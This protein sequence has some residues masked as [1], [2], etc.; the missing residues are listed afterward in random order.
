[1]GQL[2][3]D[4]LN[5]SRITRSEMHRKTVDLSA[6]AKKIATELQEAQPERQAEFI[7]AEKLIAYGDPQ[8][9]RIALTNLLGNAW[10]FTR[11]RPRARIELGVTKHDGKPVYFVRDDGDGFDMAFVNKLFGAFQRL[12]ST[13]EFEGTGIGLATVQRIIHRHGGQIWAEGTVD[14]GAT[15]YF[16]FTI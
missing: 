12:H 4:L 5:L 7:I 16:T 13:T 14:Q 3:D 2:V 8:L 11:K 6:L 9:L 1:M 10:K 15:F